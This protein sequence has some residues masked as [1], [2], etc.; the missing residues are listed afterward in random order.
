MPRKP[1]FILLLTAHGLCALAGPTEDALRIGKEAEEKKEFQSAITTYVNAFNERAQEKT[2]EDE[3][4][5]ELLKRA[6]TLL[7]G[8]GNFKVAADCYG[9]LLRIRRKLSGEKH[10]ETGKVSSLLAAQLANSGGDL[11]QA[12]QFAS[13]AVDML[14]QAGDGYREDLLV[15]LGN[16]AAILLLK[17]DRLAANELYVQLIQKCE[18]QPGKN[19]D[20]IAN[21]Y[22]SMAGI[23]GFFGRA[24]DQISYM[25][26]SAEAMAKHH[27]ENSPAAFMARINLATIQIESGQKK[28]AKALLEEIIADLRKAPGAEKDSLLQQRWCIAEYR[29]AI[30][31][32]NLGEVDAAYG[33]IKSSLAHGIKGWNE[34]H[35]QLL[36]IY[37]DL[38]RLH[39]SRKELDE[40][41]RCYQRVLD[42]RR[43]ELGPDHEDTKETQRTLSELYQETQKLKGGGKP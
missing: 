17:K 43:R 23:A 18:E 40:A 22:D 34:T 28:E 32:S 21:A 30:V 31:T 14:S 2:D 13:D 11:D 39:L 29:M 41:V 19:L 5:A 36:S 4:C 42:I 26:R 12:L 38:A 15:A 3:T 37:L 6:G 35:S 9:K 25:K 27:G 7:A 33:W 10:P 1:P 16:K 24:K 20:L 8:N